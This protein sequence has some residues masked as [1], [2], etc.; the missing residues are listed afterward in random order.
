M[1]GALLL[2]LPI[3]SVPDGNANLLDCLF[4]ATSATC[5]TGLVVQDTA[6]H[7]TYFGQFVIL[8][9]IQLGGM[10]VLTVAMVIARA[11]GRS[12]DLRQRSDLQNSISAPRLGGILHLA[13]FIIVGTLL[14]ELIGTALLYLVF[15]AYAGPLQGIW[16]S[17]FHSISA[18][19]N[20]GFDIM[21]DHTGPY[22]SM[23]HFVGNPLLNITITALIIW[24]GL[25]FLTWDDLRQ[26]DWRW[27]RYSMQTKVI[28]SYTA[29]L[30]LVPTLYFFFFELQDMP[31]GERFWAAFFQ[32]VT[33]RTAGYNTVDF[34]RFSDTGIFMMII[35]MLIGGSPGSTA[36]G[37]KNTTFAVLIATAISVYRRRNSPQCFQRRITEETVRQALAI[38]AIYLILFSCSAMAI[39]SIEKLPLLACMFETAS[40]LATVGVTLGITTKL[41]AISKFILIVLMFFGRVGGLTIIYAAIKYDPGKDARYPQ[42]KLTVG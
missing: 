40:A 18:F 25:G 11:S 37:I 19:C 29:L 33:V 7:W 27:I 12:L 30:L 32:T 28:L 10:G 8:V 35:L 21:G 16:L 23:T 24:G 26:N 22:S 6:T 20:A 41:G 13:K 38:L 1:L 36:G 3:S 34:N 31:T 15:T 4:T 5:V 42:G 2:W 9:L 17:I 39:S 14:S